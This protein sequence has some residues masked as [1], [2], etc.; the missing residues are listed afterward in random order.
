MNVDE[1][2]VAESEANANAAAEFAL[3]PLDLAVGL[4]RVRALVVAVLEDQRSVGRSAYVIDAFV[5]RLDRRRGAHTGVPSSIQRLNR[6]TLSL[7]H[8]P[9]HG[10]DPALTANSGLMSFSKLGAV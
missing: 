9:S 2:E 8:G 4:A 6:S 3:D 5:E 1:R 7:G 10:I